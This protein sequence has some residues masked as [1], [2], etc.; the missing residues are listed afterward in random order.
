MSDKNREVIISI[1]N[2]FKN[3]GKHQVIKGVSCQIKKGRR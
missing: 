1:E 3:F 2:L